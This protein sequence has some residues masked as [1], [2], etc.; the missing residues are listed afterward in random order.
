MGRCLPGTIFVTPILI[1]A[2]WSRQL[3]MS[4]HTCTL[5]PIF[6]PLEPTNL[7]SYPSLLRQ[8]RSTRINVGL[9]IMSMSSEHQSVDV[10]RPRPRPRPQRSNA[11]LWSQPVPREP[12]H[13]D[14]STS[15]SSSSSS[16]S[17]SSS[18][19]SSSTSNSASTSLSDEP[20]DIE[21]IIVTA[22]TTQWEDIEPIT[23]RPRI[24]AYPCPV[25]SGSYTPRNISHYEDKTLREE[26]RRG[27]SD[28]YDWR[29]RKETPRGE[30]WRRVRRERIEEMIR[31]RSASVETVEVARQLWLRN[32]EEETMV[33]RRPRKPKPASTLLK[34]SL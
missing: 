34:L 7:H 27:G 29:A 9:L 13:S 28:L 4:R 20:D 18:R 14:S 24:I 25:P 30:A 31:T 8:T 6:K 15:G 5:P 10:S 23:L 21:S 19:T 3:Y 12:S 17:G 33:I 1:S 26:L 11:M 22:D 16:S 32:P 2:W